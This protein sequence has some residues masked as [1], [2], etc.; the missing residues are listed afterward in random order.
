[1]NLFLYSFSFLYL[2]VLTFGGVERFLTPI[3]IAEGSPG[4]HLQKMH[5]LE[6]LLQ[7]IE[8]VG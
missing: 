2:T 7:I 3:E 5:S 8:Q 6:V 4:I 1:L